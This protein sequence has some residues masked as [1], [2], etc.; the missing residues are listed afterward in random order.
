MA[1]PENPLALQ[2]KKALEAISERTELIK[3]LGRQ[4]YRGIHI[5]ALTLG[6]Q[7]GQLRIPFDKVKK[8]G[9][10]PEDE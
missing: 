5:V 2:E 6:Y 10:F 3:F 9:G 7:A 8:A 4:E 1:T